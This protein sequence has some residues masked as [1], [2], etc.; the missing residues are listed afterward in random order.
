M[1]T[2]SRLLTRSFAVGLLIVSTAH[3][4]SA[5]TVTRCNQLDDGVFRP[6]LI[7][8]HDGQTYV[9]S[10]GEDGLTR[11]TL[12]NP[13]EALAWAKARYG[14]DATVP[15]SYADACG[16]SGGGS[17]PV[18]AAAPGDDD[19]DDDDDDDGGGTF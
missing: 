13:G 6:V 1:T 10:M 18:P 7:V 2:S 19:D 8:E 9:H 17:G 5:L 14:A 12:F 16:Y 15:A 4:A 3:G 11:S